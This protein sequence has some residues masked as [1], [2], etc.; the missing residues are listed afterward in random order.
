MKKIMMGKDGFEILA[1][2][3]GGWEHFSGP[4][5]WKEL[6]HYLTNA[7]IEEDYVLGENVSTRDANNIRQVLF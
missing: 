3:N 7:P 1:P 4:Y 5:Q 6:V 2:I